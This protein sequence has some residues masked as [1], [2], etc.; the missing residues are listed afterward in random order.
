MVLGV[1]RG[2]FASRFTE[3]R[4]PAFPRTASLGTF[5]VEMPL[6]RTVVFD[7]DSTLS[8][9]EGIDELAR[10]HRDEVARLTDA[11]M[12]GAMALE[13]V[14]GPRLELVRPTRDD[15]AALG[16]RYIDEM[17]PDARDVVAALRR[18]GV[19]VRVI[20]GGLLPAVATLARALGL[21][22]DAVAAVDIRFDPSGAYADFD[23]ASPLARAGGKREVLARWAAALPRPL[24]FV[25]DGATDLEAQP[26]VD[27]FV[28]FAGVVARPGVME[29][30]DV[31]VTARSLAP[32]L[33]LALG[34]EIPAAAGDRALLERGA[35]LLDS[36]AT[37]STRAAGRAAAPNG[38]GP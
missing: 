15:V 6:Y 13:Q 11:A 1:L 38:Q 34:E 22:D 23:A 9:I 5:R 8:T 10:V 27:S 26:V 32:I 12:S 14:Y 4:C 24:M 36:A 28:A 19:T 3:D 29:A 21:D 30:A 37:Q 17:V 20:S 35:R 31:V 2:P 33:A 7:C 25:G 16:R 18:A